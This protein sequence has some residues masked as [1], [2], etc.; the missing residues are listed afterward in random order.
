MNVQKSDPFFTPEQEPGGE[1]TDPH[2]PIILSRITLSPHTVVSVV[3][4]GIALSLFQI[5][6]AN[7]AIVPLLIVI[8]IL[9]RPAIDFLSR[10][11]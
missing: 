9:L 5:F 1:K 6:P 3:L 10:P 8:A 11:E 4:L 2:K 7:K